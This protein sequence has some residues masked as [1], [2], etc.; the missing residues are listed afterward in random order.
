[1]ENMNPEKSIVGYGLFYIPHQEDEEEV[2]KLFALKEDV[3]DI[4]VEKNRLINVWQYIHTVIDNF[5]ILPLNTRQYNKCK[6]IED[7]DLDLDDTYTDEEIYF[8]TN[9]VLNTI[10]KDYLKKEHEELF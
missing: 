1:M 6:F 7:Y 9:I 10:I 8:R 4:E 3:I 2:Y 5:I